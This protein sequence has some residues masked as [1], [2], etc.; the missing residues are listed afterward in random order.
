MAKQDP[1]LKDLLDQFHYHEALD[2][3]HVVMETIDTHLTQHP[4]LKLNKDIAVLV[5]EAQTK[6]FQAYQL[7]GE[8]SFKKV[9]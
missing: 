1:T 2:R 5:E 3:L 8:K 7:A 4:V 9:E 6:L